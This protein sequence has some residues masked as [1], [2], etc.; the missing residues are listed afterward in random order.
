MMEEYN[1]LSLKWRTWIPPCT[2]QYIQL[3]KYTVHGFNRQL[4]LDI[5]CI[6]RHF[7]W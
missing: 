4:F 5:S 2:L 1:D 3:K 7:N 6:F